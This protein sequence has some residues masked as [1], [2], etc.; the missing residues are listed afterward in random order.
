MKRILLFVHYDKKNKLDDRI[1]YT[2]KNIRHLFDKVIVVS[3]S[4]LSDDDISLLNTVS[5]KVILRNNMGFDF[6]AWKEGIDSVGWPT[7]KKYDS[8]TL[9]NDTCHCPIW[10]IDRYFEKFDKKLNIDFWGASLH[11]TTSYGMPGTNKPVPEHI[12]SY[13]MT[14]KNDVIKSRAF[15]EFWS[16]TK[17]HTDVKKVIRDYEVGMTRMLSDAGF[18]YD[19]IV[20]MRNPI[21]SIKTIVNPIFQAPLELLN[22]KFPFIKL[23]AVSKNNFLK[24]RDLIKKSSK[25][26]ARYIHMYGKNKLQ[27]MLL[28]STN[29]LLKKTHL[30][31][32]AIAIPTVI[33]FSIITPPGFGGDEMSHALRAYSISQGQ[34]LTVDNPVPTNLRDTLKYGWDEAESASWGTQFYRR[35]DLGSKDL[36]A[37][38]NLA[39]KA[40]DSSITTAVKFSNTDAY[41]PLV[42]LGAAFGFWIGEALNLSVHI[43]II[44]ARLLN[45]MPFFILGAFSIYILRKSMARWLTFTVLLLPTVL[46]YAGTING[47][48]YNIASVALFFAL[49]LRNINS[50][51]KISKRN[52]L[53]LAASSMLLSFA[54]LPSILLIGLLFFVKKDRFNSA[55]DK[56]L[57]MGGIATATI[58]LALVSMSLGFTSA[59]GDKSVAT[60]KISWSITHPIDTAALLGRTIIE[61]SPDYISRAVGVMGR[62]GVYVHGVIIMT[63]YTWLTILA[64]S[65]NSASKKKGLLLLVYS[66]IMGAIVMGLLYIGDHDNKPGEQ[67]ILGVHGKYFTPFMVM[68]FY[69]LGALAPFK[70]I[71]NKRYIGITTV[72]LMTLIAVTS[73]F[74]YELALH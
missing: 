45:A 70:I 48:P 55:K 23:K 72:V 68:A 4:S 21:F 19:A 5:D 37:L 35:Q 24:I 73:I 51:Q 54:K 32:L 74:T 2:L 17:V 10:P 61:E 13:F 30:A 52:V 65:I 29:F 44:M 33:A 39:D 62:N 47:D 36:A 42:Y 63:I 57:K 41:S 16:S 40:M 38:T 34:L 1:L 46:S 60:E 14:F 43:T 26:Q 53:L 6:S 71:S 59:V 15:V 9:M 25:Y 58:L 31:F 49:F 66:L 28:Y 3:N 7:I 27:H 69:G 56:W 11:K 8:L 18:K 50:N 67:V 22:Q 20:N 64:L 12:Q